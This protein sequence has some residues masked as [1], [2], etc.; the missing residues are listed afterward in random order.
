MRTARLLQPLPYRCRRVLRVLDQLDR[1]VLR[2]EHPEQ[3]ARPP[4]LRQPQRVLARHQ[5]QVRRR[6]SPSLVVIRRQRRPQVEVDR[7]AVDHRCRR[8]PRH[9]VP[10]VP[11]DRRQDHRVRHDRY[12]LRGLG[13][14]GVHSGINLRTGRR[15]RRRRHRGLLRRRLRPRRHRHRGAR[16]RRHPGPGSDALAGPTVEV[17]RPSVR[18]QMPFPARARLAGRGGLRRKPQVHRELVR[19]VLGMLDQPFPSTGRW[20]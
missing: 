4:V 17:L 15:P 20:L 10:T 12:H 6:Q 13:H 16:R 3:I 7:S 11:V 5:E 2:R 8:Q 19:Q 18:D 9:G 14:R 1:R